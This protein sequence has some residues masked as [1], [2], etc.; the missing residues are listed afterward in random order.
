MNP[1]LERYR[2]DPATY[3]AEIERRARGLRAREISRFFQRT[4]LYLKDLGHAARPHLARQ[5]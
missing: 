4:A 5:G 1:E 3:R 2:L